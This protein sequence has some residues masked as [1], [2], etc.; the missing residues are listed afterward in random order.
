MASKNHVLVQPFFLL[1]LRFVQAVVGLV[2][3]GLTA[4]GVTEFA[5]DGDSLM[6]FTV[7]NA[8]PLSSPVI[9]KLPR[10]SLR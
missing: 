5:F 2:I 3:L 8:A 4:Y 10:P 9:D 1:V 6:L 7:W